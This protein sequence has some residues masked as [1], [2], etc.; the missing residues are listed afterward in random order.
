[1]WWEQAFG[2]RLRVRIGKHRA[3]MQLETGTALLT[4]QVEGSQCSVMVGRL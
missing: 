2:F 4:E 1:M 3:Q